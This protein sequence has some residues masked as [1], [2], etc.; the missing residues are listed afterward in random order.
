[1]DIKVNTFDDH[2][3]AL[4]RSAQ[5]LDQMSE[6]ITTKSIE[7]D[8]KIATLLK[9]VNLKL[10]D[11]TQFLTLQKTIL[12]NEL[13]YMKNIKTIISTS[14][15]T[16][17]LTLAENVTMFLMSV[18]SIYKEI[19]NV[20]TKHAL[21]SQKKDNISKIIGDI[22]TNLNCLRNILMEFDA[23][24]R[25]FSEDIR[26][27]NFHCL[28][29]SSDMRTVYT[30][31]H[32]EYSKYVNDMENRMLYYNT[33]ASN[34]LEQIPN[35]RICN[36]YLPPEMVVSVSTVAQEIASDLQQHRSSS[37]SSSV[38]DADPSHS[39]SNASSNASPVSISRNESSS[40]ASSSNTLLNLKY[41][42]RSIGSV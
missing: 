27:G 21:V 10:E 3:D 5:L 28:T 40:N 25:T 42:S 36:Y 2:A 33:F 6:Q 24:N 1:M 22:N 12:T 29:L 34:I 18:Q 23:F 15:K 16:Q 30:H 41:E 39:H 26:K 20:E 7:I 14:I 11:S 13:E 19:P 31:I 32:L 35:M 38:F 4:S 37:S 8:E 9:K 17:L